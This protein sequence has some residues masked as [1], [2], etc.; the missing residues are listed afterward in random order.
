MKMVK[1]LIAVLAISAMSLS[2]VACGNS[3]SST[4]TNVTKE[5]KS[6]D[7][8]EKTVIAVVNGTPIYKE[9]LYTNYLTNLE[10]NLKSQ[11]GEDY[12]KDETAKQNFE[13]Q[14]KMILQNLVET[15]VLVE[16]AKE[17][18]I[19]VTDE[20]VNAQVDALKANFESEQAFNDRLKEMDTT[21]DEIK[22]SIKSDLLIG[23][24]IEDMTK[25]VEVTEDEA[26]TFYEEN[27]DMYRT[28]AGAEMAHILVKTED[29]AKKVKAEYDKGTSFEELA[30]R[31][32]TD[33]TKDR[34][35]ALGFIEYDSPNYDADFLAG[36]KNL[37]EGQVSEPV[38]TQFGWHLIKV[39]NIQKEP[40]TKTFDEVK[41]QVTST[42]KEQK[43]YETF[44]KKLDEWK[45]DMKIETYED[46]L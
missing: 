5:D 1:R 46:R 18:N 38:E 14:K 7:Q 10:Q 8:A 23:K 20:E 21:L 36:A 27:S 19:K 13:N 6:G 2:M 3:E 15:Q 25:D 32:G 41:D 12:L 34:G 22:E 42:V 31:Y 37:T 45:S 24:V 29:E 17:N 11:Y 39:T 30:A 9:G 44:N 33:G 28:Q 35:G 16:K 40:V 26:K 4:T 43:S